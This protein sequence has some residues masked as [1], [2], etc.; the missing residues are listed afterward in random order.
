[1]MPALQMGDVGICVYL[2]FWGLLDL[3]IGVG[4]LQRSAWGWCVAAIGYAPWPLLSIF[5]VVMKVMA[6]A[7]G[8]APPR[9]VGMFAGI[10]VTIAITMYVYKD[11]TRQHFGL[12]SMAPVIICTIIG[13][14]L[15]IGSIGLLLVSG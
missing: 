3:V 14:I 2:L 1:M 5:N 4:L 6:M 8:G 7:D 11:E 9:I 15:G 12:T 10:G 13:V